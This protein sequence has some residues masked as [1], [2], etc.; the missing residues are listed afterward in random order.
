MTLLVYLLNT[1]EMNAT[2][3]VSVK[4][5]IKKSKETKYR[6]DHKHSTYCFYTAIF[7]NKRLLIFEKL[8]F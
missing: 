8:V 2:S 7:P 1:V 6:K 4:Y 3:A 5:L